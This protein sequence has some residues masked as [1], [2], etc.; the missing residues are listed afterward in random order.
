MKYTVHVEI[1]QPI[2]RVM[3][4]FDNPDN[5]T[6]WMEGLQSFEHISGTPGQPG[7]K[8]K[9][10]FLIRKKEMEMIETVTERGPYEMAG[11]Y[12]AKGFKNK[13][14]ARFESIGSDKTRYYNDQEFEFEGFFMR[15][16]AKLMPGT[17]KKQ[18]LKYLKAFK[19]FAESQ[20]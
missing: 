16:M 19:E 11:Y 14:R 9:L 1:D 18:S 7:S 2:D 10:V 15:I 17:F 12:E 8:S 13:I 20:S 6:K 3:E 4:L 5:L